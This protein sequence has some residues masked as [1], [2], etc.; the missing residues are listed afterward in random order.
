VRADYR[1]VP[2]PGV[3]HWIADEAPDELAEAVLARVGS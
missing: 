3:S 1:F 2:L